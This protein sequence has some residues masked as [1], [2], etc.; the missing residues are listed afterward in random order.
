MHFTEISDQILDILAGGTLQDIA[1]L[2][3]KT[4]SIPLRILD[5]KYKVLASMP[6]EKIEDAYFDSQL[7]LDMLPNTT[8]ISIFDNHYPEA[9]L[10]GVSYIDW[11]DIRYPRAA[12]T[13]QH[14]KQV[15]AHFS[16]I[17]TDRTIS[18]EDMMALGEYLMRIFR[19]YFSNHSYEAFENEATKSAILS[20]LFSGNTIHEQVLR[21]WERAIDKPL[22]GGFQI[23]TLGPL[24]YSSPVNHIVSEFDS[25]YS[26]NVSGVY[27]GYQFTL[28]Y[29]LKGRKNSNLVL[30]NLKDF[31]DSYHMSC[32]ASQ[33]Y[34]DINDTVS[35]L[36]QCRKA[37]E[38]GNLKKDRR[39]ILKYDELQ[40]DILLS[41]VMGNVDYVNLVHPLF[42]ALKQEDQVNKTQYYQ[43]L[44]TYIR[45]LTD[46]AV[47]CKNLYIHRNTL[48]YRLNHIEDIYSCDLHDV[49]LIDN[50]FLS[51][52]LMDLHDEL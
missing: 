39:S 4:Y 36:F 26:N 35:Y 1:E 37:F 32:G 31:L 17:H 50:L 21:D 14:K 29:N 24:V 22:V 5:T 25:I 23:I 49:E 28:L 51:L 30:S 38:I 41:Y 11:G 2:V 16:L 13:V 3:Y 15:Y 33:I 7:S 34:N 52:M 40:K 9:M 6:Q 27:D 44:V 12:A 43:T 8:V 42:K 10:N 20:Y 19:I 45:N 18:K 48:L 46:R 47:T